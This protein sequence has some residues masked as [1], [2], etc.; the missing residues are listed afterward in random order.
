MAR[1]ITNDGFYYLLPYVNNTGSGV[2][3]RN[4]GARV[5][6]AYLYFCEEL[7]EEYSSLL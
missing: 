1:R 7:G 2:T 6:K 3:L 4:E 5:T